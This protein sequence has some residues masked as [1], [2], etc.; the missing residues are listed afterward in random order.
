MA[1]FGQCTNPWYLTEGEPVTYMRMR[2]HSSHALFIEALEE[3]S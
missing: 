1:E 3:E 2:R